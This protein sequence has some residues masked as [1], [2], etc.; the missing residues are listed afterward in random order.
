MNTHQRLVLR[1]R[2]ARFNF[3]GPLLFAK[4]SDRKQRIAGPRLR[5]KREFILASHLPSLL[6]TVND[7]LVLWLARQQYIFDVSRDHDH[8]DDMV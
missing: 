7:V 6:D 8:Q 2:H 3:L 4:R 1:L 5:K